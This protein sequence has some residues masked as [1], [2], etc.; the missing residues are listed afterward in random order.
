[1]ERGAWKVTNWKNYSHAGHNKEP[2]ITVSWMDMY[3][4]VEPTSKH[5]YGRGP[6]G[7]KDDI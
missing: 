3:G 4:H 1:V 5:D 6:S 2:K 7:K